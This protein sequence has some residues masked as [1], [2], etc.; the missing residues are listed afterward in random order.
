MLEL[1]LEKVGPKGGFFALHCAARRGDHAA[2]V[3]LIESR[4]YNV[5]AAD[6]DGYTPLMLAARQGHASVCRLLICSGAICDITTSR[7]E[8]ALR[9]ASGEAKEVILDSHARAVVTRGA[10]LKKHTKGGKGNPHGKLVRIVQEE[11]VL[12]WG[13]NKRRNVVCCGAHVGPSAGFL[14]NRKGKGDAAEPGLFRVRTGS[15]KEV[16]FVCLG[17]GD[18]GARLWVRGILLLSSK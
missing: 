12:R 10:F 1:T 15:G 17:E 6:V 18:E 3:R 4:R 5:N 16:H 7:G 9:M 14:K 2:A 11:G 8:T 13:E